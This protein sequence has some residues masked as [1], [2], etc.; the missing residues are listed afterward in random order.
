[1]ALTAMLRLF[2][3]LRYAARQLRR[4]PGFTAITV[5]TL[6]LGIAASTAVFAV[7]NAIVFRPAG[8]AKVD[9]VMLVHL[10]TRRV[11]GVI[12]PQPPTFR[13]LT[14]TD[15]QSFAAQPPDPIEAAAG[16]QWATVT[17]RIPGK[18][19]RVNAEAVAGDYQRGVASARPRGG[20][21]ATRMPPA[22]RSP[23]S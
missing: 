22:A 12:L 19:E 17:I 7:V 4:T 20:T 13:P 16:V 23:R 18:A 10:V 21:A 15:F 6:A 1:M 3:D 9:H 8:L 2:R 14:S 11:K 5:L